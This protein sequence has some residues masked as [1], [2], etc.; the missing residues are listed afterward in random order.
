MRRRHALGLLLCLVAGTAMGGDIAMF[1]NLGF[2]PDARVF[3]FGQYGVTATASRPFAE[4]YLVDVRGNRF[5]SDGIFTFE[6]D[7]PLSLG[8]D[9]RGAL[10]TLLGRALPLLAK[11]KVDHLAWGRPIYIRIDGGEVQPRLVFRDFHAGVRY[12]VRLT[13]ESRGAGDSVSAA[14]HID[15]ALTRS[16]A[17]VRTLRIG[18]PGFFRDGVAEYRISQIIVGPGESSIVIV[19]ERIS[20]DGTIRYMVETA[21]L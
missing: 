17:S 6:S 4:I 2:S 15:V 21:A 7:A 10:Y 19:V 3:A 12:D 18:R 5:V 9:G 11:E 1:E 16:D 20:P 8:Q 13:Q 14:F